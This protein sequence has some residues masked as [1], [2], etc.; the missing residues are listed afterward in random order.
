MIINEEPPK[1]IQDEAAPIHIDMK[2]ELAAEEQKGSINFECLSQGGASDGSHR[3]DELEL[4]IVEE[5]PAPV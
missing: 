2:Q 3:S 1:L 4:V 5:S